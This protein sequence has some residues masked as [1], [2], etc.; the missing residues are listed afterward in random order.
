MGREESKFNDSAYG[1]MDNA[2]QFKNT[3]KPYEFNVDNQ[4]WYE[5]RL[6]GKFPERRAYHTCFF[7]GKR[8][9]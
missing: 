3:L 5:L 8:Y 2:S 1:A 9:I 6:I 4:N 7:L